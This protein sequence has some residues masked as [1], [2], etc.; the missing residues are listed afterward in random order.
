MNKHSSI[1]IG[2]TTAVIFLIIYNISAFAF[3]CNE[4]RANT[5][6]LHVIANSDSDEDQNI[7]LK[8]RDALLDAGSNIFDGTVTPANAQKKIANEINNLEN[9][10]NRVLQKYNKN[11]HATVTL[12]TE[13]FDTRIYDDNITLPAGKYLALKVVL[14]EG[15]GKNWWCVM[16]PSLCLP[17]TEKTNNNSLKNTY[18]DSEKYI[19]ENQNKYEIHFK[20]IEIIEIIKNKVDIQH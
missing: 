12:T 14:G 8:V 3:Q 4:I 13:Y 2:I 15:N 18:T 20:I 11:Y 6:R 7:K 9:T 16:F 5:I 19:I 17:A 1:T 10:A